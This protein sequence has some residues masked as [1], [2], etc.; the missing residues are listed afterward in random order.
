MFENYDSN[1]IS[2]ETNAW[3]ING[4]FDLTNSKNLGDMP[5][6]TSTANNNSSN[7]LNAW[8][9]KFVN[10]NNV[11][12]KISLR[13]GSG[14]SAS[15]SFF[16]W[17]M[18]RNISQE[19]TSTKIKANV[20]LSESTNTE[21]TPH[22]V[23]NNDKHRALSSG[24]SYRLSSVLSSDIIIS[25]IYY[26]HTP[27]SDNTS[28]NYS[29]IEIYNPTASD[30]DL[31]NYGIARIV[32]DKG[33]NGFFISG[34]Y[35]NTN[36]NDAS[37]ISLTYLDG[38]ASKI[39]PF[40]SNH[41]SY[42]NA[43]YKVIYGTPSTILK[44]GKTLLIG[45]GG[46]GVT[47]NKP[48]ANILRYNEMIANGTLTTNSTAEQIKRVENVELPRAGMQ[49]DSAVM[50]AYAQSMVVIDNANDKDK[51][52]N[53]LT[54]AGVAQLGN[55]Q[56]IAILK[57]SND[58][59]DKSRYS[60][61]IKVVDISIPM[62]NSAD[63]ATYKANLIRDINAKK[64][65]NNTIT[66][67][68]PRVDAVFYSLVRNKK[69]AF[70][71]DRYKFDEWELA[72]SEND[73]IKSIGSRNYVAGLSP[74]APNYTAYNANNNPKGNPFWSSAPNATT[75]NKAWTDRFDL[76]VNTSNLET[77]KV[78]GKYEKVVISSASASEQLPGYEIEKSFD[79]KFDENQNSY[80]SQN[81]GGVRFPVTLFYNFDTPQPI[82]KIV[83]TPRTNG[84][85]QFGNVDVYAI[86]TNNGVDTR[87]LI[88]TINFNQSNSTTE[89]EINENGEL[90]K[91]IEFIVKTANRVVSVVEMEFYKD[92]E[93]YFDPKLL[94][95][96]LACTRLKPNITYKDIMAVKNVFFREM[97]RR[98]Y[99]GTYNKE[100]RIANYKAYPNP[101]IQRVQNKT[102]FAY[103]ILDNPTGIFVKGGEEI[104]VFVGETHGN[105][106]SMRVMKPR[107]TGFN[108]DNYLLKPGMNKINIRRDGLV[109]ILYNVDN[110]DTS[111]H[112]DIT[113][114]FPE[115]YGVVNG[116]YDSKNPKHKGR[117]G[118]LLSKAKAD[119][120]DLLGEYSHV[121]FPTSKYRQN[122][123]IADELIDGYDTIVKGEMELLGL[124][125][126]NRVF[127]NRAVFLVIY[128]GGFAY[129]TSHRTAYINTTSDVMTRVDQFRPW[130]WGRGHEVG[131]MN[132]T[133]GMNWGGMIEVTNNVF[134]FHVS[135]LLGSDPRYVRDRNDWY[136]DSWN[137]LFHKDYTFSTKSQA[138]A[139][140][141]PFWQLELYFG[142][143]LGRTPQNQA[144]KGGFY[145]D[146]FESLR[147][148][149]TVANKEKEINNED[150]QVDFTYHA[151]KAA[152]MDLTEFFEK[153][154]FFRVSDN[155]SFRNTY[156]HEFFIIVRNE[157]VNE[158]KNRIK[159]MNLPK[160]RVAIEYINDYNWEM[161]R[162]PQPVIV[163]TASR[164]ANTIILR[165]WQ[166]VVAWEV[167]DTSANNQVV[168]TS[169]G[170]ELPNNKD[171]RNSKVVLPNNLSW[172]TSYRLQAISASG[173]RTIVNN[174]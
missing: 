61:R 1:A 114:H 4:Y 161:Y 13:A 108:G 137:L 47:D 6:W 56:G 73:G 119:H 168:Y 171:T 69:V 64:G 7:Y 104:V 110:L 18:P 99:Q 142:K 20:R 173:T 146:L 128:G 150:Q 103:S 59:E 48:S 122:T 17:G 156:S 105:N 129:A 11:D 63:E 115:G 123:P 38:D 96:D 57:I 130:P 93:G 126:Y 58:I 33:K 143:A 164:D 24:Q 135:Y 65:A 76:G 10:Q 141:I 23:Y 132:Q 36:P 54:Y 71:S 162:N 100:F 79:G 2:I 46:Y 136:T 102:Q 116:Y 53:P 172:N 32:E 62:N 68:R 160:P 81:S 158:V 41:T 117:W 44:A 94:F 29:I 26:Q 101:N 37:V 139:T 169:T 134:S 88:K 97:A 80:H 127:K 52:P 85:G 16:I 121:I 82:K 90:I 138:N 72:V 120:F 109:Y 166:N 113:V 83:Y 95:E 55:G 84:Y 159:S 154:G 147:T 5:S 21:Y 66:T 35:P 153:W 107:L 151:S 43:W 174:I 106:I 125:K 3:D 165:D 89:L 124:F 86:V 14:Y 155:T 74:F 31:S 152:K 8:T 9:Y 157:K 42:N 75:I 131:H 50:L 163:G 92:S 140:L 39:N 28:D 19:N 145:P 60:N 45:A 70:P 87:K 27:K 149:N 170:W 51:E 144:D 40:P 15:H 148:T 98:I 78:L 77:N 133:I 34:H 67:I 49:A 91:N 112:P 118:E 111:S 12:S 167:I 22:I 30:I 25:E